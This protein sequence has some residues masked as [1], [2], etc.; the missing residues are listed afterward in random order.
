MEIIYSGFEDKI[1]V[2]MGI[3]FHATV[4]IHHCIDCGRIEIL[5]NDRVVEVRYLK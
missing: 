2:V 1:T 3:E 4:K 5:I